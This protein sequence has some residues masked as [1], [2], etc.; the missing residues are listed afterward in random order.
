MQLHA[1]SLHCLGRRSSPT[2]VIQAAFGF[3]RGAGFFLC[4]FA[5]DLA[6]PAFARA[7]A[8]GEAEGEVCESDEET[9]VR[10]PLAPMAQR[11]SQM[12]RLLTQRT[13]SPLHRLRDF[14]HWRL[15]ARVVFELFQ[16]RLFP[17]LPLRPLLNRRRHD[18]LR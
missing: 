11:N 6:A 13:N 10:H 17:R 12:E 18:S 9:R 5:P 3:D 14:R 1:R 2:D 4:A 16:V 8:T 7:R 15:C